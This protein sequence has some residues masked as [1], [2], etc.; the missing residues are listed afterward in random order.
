M[1][2]YSTAS[3]LT[4]GLLER[5]PDGDGTQLGRREVLQAAEQAAHRG[6]GAGDQD[7]GAVGGLGTVG[8]CG[9]QED[10]EGA[11]RGVPRPERRWAG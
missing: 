11:R 10:V 4:P 2:T 1:I 7:G 5:A 3:G 8:H 9:L 6:A